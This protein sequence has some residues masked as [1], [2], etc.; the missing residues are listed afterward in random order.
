[1]VTDARNLWIKLRSFKY[2]FLG[3]RFQVSARIVSILP[4]CPVEVTPFSLSHLIVAFCMEC[5]RLFHYEHFKDSIS[6]KNFVSR[7]IPKTPTPS[8]DEVEPTDTDKVTNFLCSEEE[9]VSNMTLLA[10]SDDV[11]LS[12]YECDEDV[13]IDRSFSFVCPV[14]KL[15]NLPDVLCQLQ[16][17]FL[18]SLHLSKFKQPSS[19]TE[20]SCLHVKA[21]GIHAEYFLGTR[22][23]HV[24]RSPEVWQRAENRL[25]KLMKSHQPLRLSVRR[26]QESEN[27]VYLENTYVVY[28]NYHVLPFD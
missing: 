21:C 7:R 18:F 9:Y 16:P 3:S 13:F 10:N 11:D 1:M 22:T 15:S 25:V 19:P 20:E 4:S 17:T 26:H 2:F 5:K 8:N 12:R 23:D 6:K 24:L 14:C 28:S 27:E